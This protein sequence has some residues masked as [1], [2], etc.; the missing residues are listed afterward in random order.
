MVQEVSVPRKSSFVKSSAIS[1][2]LLTTELSPF[3]V[4]NFFSQLVN[5]F[6]KMSSLESSGSLALRQVKL[7]EKKVFAHLKLTRFNLWSQKPCEVIDM[8][9]FYSA[10]L[11]ISTFLSEDLFFLEL[12][13]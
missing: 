9:S 6:E 4:V 8:F 13:L 12:I 10:V 2:E 1:N 5:F 7:V 11:V 3:T